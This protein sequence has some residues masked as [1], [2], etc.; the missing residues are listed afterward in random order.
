MA[1]TS[2]NDWDEG[3]PVITDA[4]RLGAGEINNLRKAVRLR[5][6]KEHVACATAG[7]GGEHKAGSGRPYY[8][9]T[10][11]TLRPDGVTALGASDA[12]REW[13]DS[14]DNSRH[15]WSGTAWVAYAGGAESFDL[16]GSPG[17]DESW[18]SALSLPLTTPFATPL[19][20]SGLSAG[21]WL[22]FVSGVFQGSQT[23]TFTI[24][25]NGQSK[26]YTSAT[27]VDGHVPFMMCIRLS[28]TSANHYIRITS[29]SGTITVLR[30][31]SLT[32]LFIG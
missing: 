20:I 13:I 14:D 9:S 7:V 16:P 17:A 23:G 3:A 32:G 15:V 8:Q 31:E 6:D 1:N 29:V 10:A 27:T 21:R 5:Q 28:V 4:R 25:A 24:T 22:L 18:T 11:P 2:A 30:I 26:S 12:G 19:Q